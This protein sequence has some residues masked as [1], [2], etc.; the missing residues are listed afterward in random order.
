ML[1]SRLTLHHTL[2]PTHPEWARIWE[3]LFELT[4]V[5]RFHFR[6]D[7]CTSPGLSI[8]QNPLVEY[9][10]TFANRQPTGTSC[11][12]ARSCRVTVS[13]TRLPKRPDSATHPDHF[14]ESLAVSPKVS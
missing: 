5:H 6:P 2:T 9:L 12:Q 7:F 14:R 8:G 4:R 11:R 3:S 13:E 10:A 1:H